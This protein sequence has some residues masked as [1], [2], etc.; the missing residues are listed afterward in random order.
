MPSMT[1]P[2]RTVIAASWLR[3]PSL[4]MMR[5]DLWTRGTLAKGSS[6]NGG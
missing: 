5:L 1:L 3:G 4:R 6:L 2:Q